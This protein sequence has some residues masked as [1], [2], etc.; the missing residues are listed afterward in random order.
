MFSNTDV[1]ENFSL[2]IIVNEILV[3][4]NKLAIT[5][6]VLVKKLLA[7]LEDTLNERARKVERLPQLDLGLKPAQ[8]IATVPL[9]KDLDAARIEQ[10]AKLLK[11]RLSVPGEHIIHKGDTGDAMYFITSGVVEVDLEPEP[12]SLGSGEFFGEIALV[13]DHPRTTDVR[14]KSFCDLLVLYKRDFNTL[15]ASNPEMRQTIH[16]VSDERAG[17]VAKER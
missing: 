12:F 17:L 1:L 2:D 14:T 4:I 13:N 16:L 9:F 3:I 6:V 10:I 7:D 8:L 15:L 11:P 5:A